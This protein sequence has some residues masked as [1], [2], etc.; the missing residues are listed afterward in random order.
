MD[1]VR[2]CCRNRWAAWSK[3]VL[4][5]KSSY[6]RAEHKRQEEDPVFMHNGKKVV[7][8]YGTYDLLHHGHIRLMERAKALGD[9]LIVGITSDAFDRDRGKL[10]VYQP[11][12]DRMNA[13]IATGI[14]DKV[15]V[16]EF[17]GQKISDIQKYGVDVF[18]IGS[19]WEGKFDYLKRYCDVVYLERT[20]GVSS[21]ELR[22]ERMHPVTMGILGLNYVSDWVVQESLHVSNAQVTC[23]CPLPGDDLGNFGERFG[24]TLEE[25]PDALIEQVD[26]VYINTTIDQRAAFIR[27]ALEA[28]CHV[29]CEGSFALTYEEGL[30]LASL[31]K[32]RGLV[33]MEAM[34]TRYFPGF[35]HLRLLIESGVIGEV[36][37]IRAA[38]SHVNEGFDQTKKY[39][40]S[41]YDLSPYFALPA[42]A[43]LGC[44][45]KQATI[46][47]TIEDGFCT[48][49]K[50]D[51]IY[52]NATA[53]LYAGQGVKT[54]NDMVITGTKGY[55]YVPAPWWKTEYFEVRS[56]DL[57]NTRKFYY[58]C[59]GH[60]HRYELFEF[61]RLIN[62]GEG[63]VPLRPEQESLSIIK[64]VEKF[65]SGDVIRLSHG[66]YS[67]GGGERITD[68]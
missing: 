66:K 14:P 37:D 47:C 21:T 45:Y 50:L 65:D 60:G 36:K 2:L 51:L 30:E 19:D 5:A 57:R 61:L 9:Y 7:I 49:S 68:R 11:L 46:A 6:K 22:A 40:G 62:E 52:E 33:L 58:E 20:R 44:D 24:L 35:E 8:T 3:L 54:E 27:K 39:R 28:G 42:F 48:W 4:R 31:A 18:A 55:V 29:L 38:N 67:F 53:T 17:Q 16:E 12:S 25:R 32:E 64:L 34:K 59:V 63:C 41:F 15:V 10:N 56:E 13:V 23:F 1:A 26:S 43:L